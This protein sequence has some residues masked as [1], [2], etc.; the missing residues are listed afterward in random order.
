MVLVGGFHPM[1][2]N[3][4]KAYEFFFVKKKDLTSTA[5]SYLCL[6]LRAVC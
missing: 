1:D 2:S 4:S 6:K 3:F 5:S